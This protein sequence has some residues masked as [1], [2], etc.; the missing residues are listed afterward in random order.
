MR[1]RN[2]RQLNRYGALPNIIHTPSWLH[3]VGHG[4]P[5]AR[6]LVYYLVVMLRNI[7][8]PGGL[9]LCAMLLV[10][11][12]SETS[13]A[14]KNVRLRL[15]WGSDTVAKARWTGQISVAGG[16]LSDLQPLGIEVDAPVALSIRDNHLVVR[17]QE[18]RGFDG[19]D[20]NV[21]ADEQALVR[22][23]LKTDQAPQSTSIEVPLAEIIA[24]EF[25]QPIDEFGSY[26]LAHR[27]PGDKLRVL[28]ARDH[29]VFAPAESWTLSVQPDLAAE[30]TA[31]PVELE[32]LLRAV[33]SDE[34][35][36]QTS[37][38]LVAG[39]SLEEQLHFEIMCPSA[40]D[41]YRLTILARRQESLATRFVPGRQAKV[42][43][44]RDVEFVVIDPGAKL[45][46]LSDQWQSVLTVD[47]A[48]PRWWQRLPSWTQVPGLSEKTRAS[49][50]NIRPVVRPALAGDLVELPGASSQGE[51]SWQAYTLPVRERRAL[52][53]IEVEYPLALEQHLAISIVEPDAAGRV[54]EVKQDSGFYSAGNI[55]APDGQTG[56]HRF[57]FWPRSNTPQLI[58]VN[59]HP[60]KPAQY[61]KIHLYSQDASVLESQPVAK[62]S[63]MV[64]GYLSQP[65]FAENFGASE[66][67]DAASGLSLQ[68]WST[69][70]DG[71]HRLVQYL[72][73]NG[74]N[75]V[76]LSVAADGSALYPS[77]VIRPS[78]RYDTGM[79][80]AR[81]Q[82]PHRKDV[83]EMLL[84]IF[85]RE[86]IRVVPTIQLA[87]PLPRL[88]RQQLDASSQQTGIRWIGRDGKSWL[89]QH[90]TVGG[91]APCYNPLNPSVQKEIQALIDELI[92]RYHQHPALAGVGIQLAGNG[93]GV[94]PGLAWGMDD[95]TVADFMRD[96]GIQVA[97]EGPQ[98]FQVR[99]DKLLGEHSVPWTQWRAQELSGLYVGLAKM[100]S[101][102]R[103]DLQL[104]LTTESLFAGRSLQQR[105]RESITN[106]VNLSQVLNEHGIDLKALQAIPGITTFAPLRQSANVGLQ[107]RALDL[108]LSAANKRG[109]LLESEQYAPQLLYHASHDFAL[110][111]YDEVNPFGAKRS[112]L[113]LSS[114]GVPANTAMRQQLVAKI[115]SQDTP[116]L[117]VGGEQMSLATHTQ[118]RQVLSTIAQLPG[119]ET[120][121]RTISKQPLVMR[122]FR[123][124]SETTIALMN[125]S[126]WPVHVRIP[127]DTSQECTWHKLGILTADAQ[128]PSGLL[129]ARA[130]QW[131]V[132][133][134]PHDLQAWSFTTAKLRVGEPLTSQD[135][136]V[137]QD[138][139]KRIQQI[140][141]RTGN[142][143]IERSYS[144][145]QNSGFELENIDTRIV[146]WQPF[147]GALG[148]IQLE[149]RDAHQGAFA[150]RLES[151]D[152]L[153]V[154]IQSNRF[155]MPETGQLV[156]S[157]FL[158]AKRWNPEARLHIA[159]EDS[160]GGRFYRQFA[161]LGSE[162]PLAE[163][164]KRYDFPVDDIPLN[165][166]GQ[167]RVRYHLTGDAEVLIDDIQLCDLR[168]NEGFRGALVKRIYAAK[169]ALEQGHVVDCLQVVDEYWSR[170]LV[171]YVPTLDTDTAS[172]Q[173]LPGE[174]E[175]ESTESKGLRSHLKG[176]VP[177]IWR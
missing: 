45:P 62:T 175:K 127:F 2:A 154:A 30:L 43:V 176:W 161:Q 93:Y 73:L 130:E 149:D 20:L 81:G 114:Q 124:E 158:K 79:M 18:R 67:L 119:P 151:E 75:S 142:L 26:F 21:R 150:L 25:S 34:I 159:I 155:P 38:Q 47:P 7:T 13:A 14:E 95:S 12:V 53:L 70:L 58:L 135:D 65:T 48:N 11:Y 31:G 77:E 40:E 5:I 117:V 112:H 19:C 113:V 105:L 131:Q 137:R 94:L 74:Q 140:E 116:T 99:A 173:P 170:Y 52:H 49:I 107:Q 24:G 59:R 100:L 145:L 96:T 144:Q 167:I 72:R 9:V 171:E 54:M 63:R 132:E 111:S 152:E 64:A 148:A 60:T 76:L 108:R 85:D 42:L 66:T 160:E 141:A 88:E 27:A 10:A 143:D 50:G 41:A 101:A 103:S 165:S 15:A 84:R 97:C 36:W 69:F 68:S 138:L 86:G 136:L 28:P 125:Q 22:I 110:P 166:R 134:Q 164:W 71:A 3:M 163:D 89:E 177:K 106:P 51:S 109:E 153:G 82:D 120:A 37:Q 157:A 147:Q 115:A 32:V 139:E 39:S 29:Y 35:L 121:V 80:S 129:A 78:P 23:S 162:A 98:R 92:H 126:P 8:G 118:L 123:S 83:L 128:R 56:I 146:G 102:Q 44:Q 57:V 87:T 122:V 174:I 1:A 104:F 16:V 55:V 61:G 91:L 172:K 133:L 90:G 156:V 46:Q 169:I 168:F 6:S 17:S 33:G 4:S